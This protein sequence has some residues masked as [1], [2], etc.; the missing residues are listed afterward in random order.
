MSINQQIKRLL[1][2]NFH[3]EH[4]LDDSRQ[5]PLSP[6][7]QRLNDEL[8]CTWAIAATPENYLWLPVDCEPNFFESLADAGLPLLHQLR[9]FTEWQT[10]DSQVALCPWGWTPE[11][12]QWADSNNVP[13][14]KPLNAPPFETVRQIN[15]RRFSFHLEQEWNV[16]IPGAAEISSLQQLTDR[17]SRLPNNRAAWVIK[18]EFGM[19]A[20]ERFLGR[21]STVT[22]PLK[23]WANKRL[24]KNQRLIF[25][26]WVNRIA[27][28]GLQ[29]EIPKNRPPKLLGVTPLLTDSTGHYRGNIFQHNPLSQTTTHTTTSHITAPINWEESIAIGQKACEAMQS[30]G[31]WGPVGIDAICYR[32]ETGQTKQ[33]PLQDINARWTMGRLSL[34]LSRLLAPNETGIWWHTRWPTDS[35]TAPQQA[36]QQFTERLPPTFRTLRTSPFTLNNHPVAHGTTA[37]ITQKETQLNQWI[38]SQCDQKKC[39]QKNVTRKNR[40]KKRET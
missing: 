12:E 4:S 5:K 17:L 15:S 38:A 23:N 33:R 26:P 30:H 32:T 22:E 29:F 24:Q 13:L 7:L 31:Y 21:G 10:N 35:P 1:L 25:E 16:G 11:V 28:V 34:G 19:S 37:I 20:R 27:E 8:A 2:G 39:D 3:F 14:D 6:F 36:Y 9:S 40:R 18:A